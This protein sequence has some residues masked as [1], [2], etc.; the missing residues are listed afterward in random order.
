MNVAFR[1]DA[2]A[3]IGTGHVMRCLALADSLRTRGAVIRFVCRGLPAHFAALLAERRY[4]LA[5]IDAASPDRDAEE[6]I[7]ALAGDRWDWLVVDHYGLASRWET[8]VRAV[9]RRILVIDDLADRDHD[10]D[11]LLDQNLLVET[12]PRYDTRVPAHTCRLFGPRFALLRESVRQARSAVAPRTGAVSRLL[13]MF[14]GADADNWTGRAVD[15]VAAAGVSVPH[16][17]VVIGALHAHRAEI[18]AACGRLG[19]VCHVQPPDVDALMARADLAIGAGGVTMWERCCLGVP[20]LTIVVAENQREMVRE[21]A[22][23]DV[24]ATLSEGEITVASMSRHLAALAGDAARR[25]RLSRAGM[26]AVDGDGTVRVVRAMETDGICMREATAADSDA[27]FEWR[28][29]ESVR[30][31]ARRPDPIPAADHRAWLQRV[32]ADPDRVLLIGERH[33]SPVGVVRFDITDGRAEVSTYRVP[34][35]M[36]TSLAAPLMRAADEWLRV[37]RP[38]VAAITAEVIGDNER[39]HRMLRASGYRLQVAAYEKRLHP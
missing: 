22:R 19:F 37:H 35:S 38:D 9:A 2:S 16:V 14:G 33:G 13:V 29:H 4:G 17:D 28:N 1:V 5:S 15:A 20:S 24:V 8:A 21:S 27:L 36:G 23:R 6:T 34:G 12:D 3:R 32:L 39:S 26:D 30:R 11:V 10:C 7:L 18:E 31:Y 25:E